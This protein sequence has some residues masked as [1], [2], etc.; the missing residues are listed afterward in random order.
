MDL[1]KA[2]NFDESNCTHYEA[3]QQLGDCYTS[4]GD[5]T[6]AQCCY[7]KAASIG[8]DEPGPYVGLGVIALQKNLLEDA[9]IA[10]RVACRLE[11]DCAKAH[12]GLAII[13]QQRQDY[14]Q[15]FE[16]YMKC[17]ELE[18][19]NIAALL[20]LFQTSCQMGSF[21]KIIYYLQTYLEMHPGDPA[22]S[23]SLATLYMKDGRFEQSQ[24]ILLDILTA[25]PSNHNAA[26]LLEE[27]EHNLAKTKQIGAKSQ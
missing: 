2:E 13:Y 11:P 9:E 6:K 20:G 1:T 21:E 16:L 12:A 5:Y 18:N 8:P 25:D 23:F 15:A 14:Q 10:F 24:K 27:V 7:E 22:V 26:D 3:L 17:L 4:V 19:D